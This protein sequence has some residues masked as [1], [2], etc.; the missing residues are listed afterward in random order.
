LSNV[1]NSTA[2]CNGCPRS[3]G[4]VDERA[5][6]FGG[7]PGYFTAEELARFSQP[8]AGELGNTGRNYF[9]APG[10]FN[11]DAALIKRTYFTEKANFEL[12]FEFFN[13][14]NHTV[15]N[16]P[17]AVFTS[18]T[19]GRIRDSVVSESR[20]IRIGAKINF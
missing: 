4:D 7:V 11:L 13:A 5:S 14:L 10:R 12:R 9:V 15:F 18:T 8:A 20:K 17:T 6:I 19:F 2:N 16:L 3:M 1:V